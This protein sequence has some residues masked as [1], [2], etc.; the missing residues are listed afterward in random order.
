MQRVSSA[1]Q[2][3]QYVG[4]RAKALNDLLGLGLM[5]KQAFERRMKASAALSERC[6]HA[7]RWRATIEEASKFLRLKAGMAIEKLVGRTTVV[8]KPFRQ[9]GYGKLFEMSYHRSQAIAFL[10]SRVKMAY[11]RVG[12][13]QQALLSLA[14]LGRRVCRQQEVMDEQQL[15]LVRRGERAR[16]HCCMQDTAVLSLIRLGQEQALNFLERQETALSWLLRRGARAVE[17]NVRLN[18]DY[19]ALSGMAYRSLTLLNNREYAFAYLSQRRDNAVRLLKAKTEA[20]AFLT[21]LAR[22]VWANADKVEKAHLWLVSRGAR[23]CTHAV[24]S[25][26]NICR[27]NLIYFF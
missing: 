19:L 9:L 17:F 16:D 15:H 11:E 27:R 10:R 25:V 18:A 23:A 1:S 5:G 4:V 26:T 14:D 7:R 24:G 8:E 2:Y 13:R 21:R 22:S 20:V 6:N 3:L 12:R